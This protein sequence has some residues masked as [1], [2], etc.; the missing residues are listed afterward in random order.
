MSQKILK[1]IKDSIKTV[2]DYP[3]KGIMFRDVTSLMQ[4]PEAF[5]QVIDLFKAKFEN[6]GITTI[7]GTEARGFIF[8]APLAYAMGVSFVPVRKPGKLPRATLSQD[9]ALEYG[10]DTLQIHTDAIK[11][12]DSVLLVDDLLA[13]GGTMDATAHLVRQLGGTV[14]GAAFVVTLP[15]LGGE[16]RLA[17]LDVYITALIS[18]EGE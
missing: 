13:T 9:Y 14:F 18:F 15:E 8:G 4:D 11:A 3:K 2:P 17:D 16:K 10:T 6:Q 5:A 12:G 1:N 7:V